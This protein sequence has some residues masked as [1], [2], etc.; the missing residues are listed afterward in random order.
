LEEAIM[1]KSRYEYASTRDNA[2]RTSKAI[3]M[4]FVIPSL[5]SILRPAQAAGATRM[6]LHQGWVLQSSCKATQEGIV[7][8]T[9]GFKPLGWYAATVPST[10]LAAQVAAGEFKNPYFGEN[11]RGIP[12]TSYPIGRNFAELP[13]PK[14]SPYAC[15]WWYRTEFRLPK[16]YLG[17][18]VWLHFDGINYRAN[19]WLNGR[20][21][22]DARNVAGAYR[23]YEFNATTFLLQ[24]EVNVLAVETFA[25]TENDL[26]INFVDWA[27]LPPDKDMGLWRDVY[28]SASGPVTVRYPQVITHFP[29]DTLERA[30]LAVMAEVHNVS[31]QPVEGVLEGSFEKCVIHQNVKLSPGESRTVRFTPEDFPQLRVTEPKVWWPAPLGP[32]NLYSLDMRFLVAGKVSDEQQ[33]HFGIREITAE[34]NGPTPRPGKMYH[35]GSGTLVDTDTRPLLLRVNHKKLLIRGAGWAPDLLL[36]TPQE[37]LET[38]FGYIRDMNLNAIRL[39]G[40]ITSDEFFD[41]ADKM[42]VLVMAGWCCCSHW[43]EWDQWNPGDL[44]IATDSLRSQILRLRSHPSLMLW[45]NGSDFPPPPQVERA[46]IKVLQDAAWPNPYVSSASAMPSSV[47]GPSGVKMTGPYDYEPPGYWLTDTSKYGGA[48]G[49]NTETSPG[50]AIPLESSLREMIPS[51]HLWPIDDVWNFHSGAGRDF[52]NL[53]HYNAAMDAIYG[54]PVGFDDYITKS[55]AM[56]YDGERAL[57]EAYARNKYRSTGVIQWMLN[58]AWPSVVWHLYDYLLQPAGGYFGAKKAC[59]PLHVQYSYDDRSVVVVNSLYRDFSGLT[60]TAVLYDFNLKQ[61]FHAQAKFDS[62]ADSVQWVLAIPENTPAHEV[63]FLKLTL[64]DNGGQ[65]VSSN[66]YWLPSKPSS[67]DWDLERT[68]KHAYY[69][70]VTDYEDLTMLNHLP[71]VHLEASATLEHHEN[72]NAVRVQLHNPSQSLAFQIRLG[73]NEEKHKEEILPVFWQDNYLSL[74]PGESRV[75]AAHYTPIKPDV[76]PELEVAGWNIE[77]LRI[78]LSAPGRDAGK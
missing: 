11:L 76:H 7:I 45:I 26:G 65:V 2:F 8:S 28:L 19:I 6:E 23:I 37:E 5:F 77:P 64:Q 41:L 15:S 10:V 35:I 16:D 54:A 46:Y 14:D 40:K 53:N 20:K 49:F 25:Q 17:R 51:D 48:Y 32:Q 72:R 75:I 56:A 63:S 18:V 24:N 43:E 68:N 55:Q 78:P 59:E 1:K 73:L 33:I 36:R 47:T 60:S 38:Q 29:D 52:N 27:P 66:F 42:G 70:S 67:Y 34:L 39:E 61:K 9:N 22:A 3:L 4:T 31:D 58:N 44:E 21:L 71:R 57:F 74:L 12:G 50:P 69:S 62:P 30:D 13:M